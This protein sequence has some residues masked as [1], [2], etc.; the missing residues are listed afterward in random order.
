METRRTGRARMCCAFLAACAA[1]TAT[2]YVLFFEPVKEALFAA[3]GRVNLIQYAC[4]CAAVIL[5]YLLFYHL[6]FRRDAMLSGACGSLSKCR[7]LAVL[8][9]VL[10][11]AVLLIMFVNEPTAYVS[12]L[13]QYANAYV[14]HQMPAAA[15]VAIECALCGATTLLLA[16]TEDA[17]PCRRRRADAA[18]W[19]V[20]AG[21]ALLVG[22]SMYCAN[23][24]LNLYHVNAYYQPVLYVLNRVPFGPVHNSIYGHYAFFFA[25]AIRLMQSVGAGS[26]MRCFS[27]LIAGVALLS[28]LLIAYVLYGTVKNRLVRMLGIVAAG[29]SLLVIRDTTYQQLWPHRIFPIALMAAAMVFA[30]RHESRRAL[31]MTLGYLAAVVCLTWS[32]EIG[33]FALAGWACYLVVLELQSMRRKWW[34]H[35]IE[36]LLGALM[37]FFVVWAITDVY[38]QQIAIGGARLT[39]NEFMFPLLVR[40]YMTERLEL[41]LVGKLSTWVVIA[42]LLLFYVCRGLSSTRICREEPVKSPVEALLFAIAVMLLGS[43]SYAINRPVYGHFTLGYELIVVL[44][45]VPASEAMLY[46]RRLAGAGGGHADEDEAPLTGGQSLFAG[47]GL[48]ACCVLLSLAFWC[49][50]CTQSRMEYRHALSNPTVTTRLYQDSKDKLAVGTKAF[51]FGA[52]EMFGLFDLDPIVYNMNYMDIEIDGP[53][54]KEYADR[55]LAEAA[56]DPV[57]ISEECLG[58]HREWNLGGYDTFMQ[59][60]ELAET[61]G[62]DYGEPAFPCRLLYFVPGA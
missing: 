38:N 52:V 12:W 3:F 46:V 2:G 30:A 23:P 4:I 31:W 36:Y 19:I 32:T 28:Q 62:E 35:C 48:S 27:V 20:A 40:Y 57:V 16:R 14:W 60:H 22:Y 51:G 58:M 1:G 11:G 29:F 26:V 6:V 47:M 53:A 10:N 9:L 17:S 24:F 44:M 41:E 45:C 18:Y 39:L 21:M 34:I 42:G 25:P 55:L 7:M 61:W 50:F 56:N 54:P 59:T 15:F 37:V 13:P 43:Y 49:V 33:L 8:P 5:S